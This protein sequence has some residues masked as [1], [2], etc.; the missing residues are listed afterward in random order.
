MESILI[1]ETQST[2]KVILGEKGNLVDGSS[3]RQFKR[4]LPS[5]IIM[6]MWMSPACGRESRLL[7]SIPKS[8]SQTSALLA[9]WPLP[10]N[11]MMF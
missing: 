2:I 1:L 7:K 4:R 3:Y 9:I 10:Y 11:G 5:N 8:R 6:K